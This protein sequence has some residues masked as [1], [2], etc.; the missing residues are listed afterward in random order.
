[1]LMMRIRLLILVVILGVTAALL[2]TSFQASADLGS[3]LEVRFL[4]VGQGDAIH[5][6]TPDGFEILVDGGAT[7][8]VLQ[9]LAAGRSFFDHS[10]DMLIASHPDSDH[11]GGLVDVL[12]RYDVQWVYETNNINQTPASEAFEKAVV[13]EGAERVVVQAGEVIRVGASTTIE[14]FAPI[15]DTSAWPSNNASIIMRVTYGEINFLLTGDAPKA[16]EENAVRNFG[17]A[18]ES[19][20]LKLGHHGS[21]TSTSPIFLEAVKPNFAVVSAGKDNRYGH[22]HRDVLE[23]V[24]ENEI[25]IIST[26]EEG[27]ITFVTDGV[28]LWQK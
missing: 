3:N 25:E 9:K 15:G 27:T 17:S 4:D 21:D 8:A 20:V 10:I 16:V 23:R 1:M 18:L 11:I 19:E 22:P 2:V 5:I 12:N 7:A 26:A 24:K 6:V 28:N 14:F 13:A